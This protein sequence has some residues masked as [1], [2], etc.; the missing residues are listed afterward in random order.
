MRTPIDVSI[1]LNNLDSARKLQDS[2]DAGKTQF[3]YDNIPPEIQ[4]E[5]ERF[6]EGDIQYSELSIDTAM[7][8]SMESISEK[9][10]NPILYSSLPNLLD[11]ETW[12][13]QD[14]MLILSGVDPEAAIVDWSYQNFMGAEIRKPQIRHANW[15]TSASDLYDYPI[16]S[17][18]EYSSSELNRLIREMKREQSSSPEVEHQIAILRER[19]QNVEMWEKDETS[20]FKTTMLALRAEMVGILKTRWDSCDHDASLRRS[21]AFFVH[22]AES[23]GFAIEWASWARESG[24]I[25]TEPPA[26]SP[27][28]FDA[29]AEDYPKLLHIAV[30]AWDHARMGSQGTAKQR[31]TAFLNE[32][33]PELSASEKEAIAVI[34]NWQKAGGRPKTGG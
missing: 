33:Y 23:R 20:K 7:W 27:P 24:Y 6:I 2:Y 13:P 10:K 34:G 14:A 5:R 8:I 9:R 18:S 21:P 31:I 11:R 32:R 3:A 17:D 30:R 25:D 12:L 28:F 16:A 1:Y 19:L 22:W 26:T 4:E 15:F 29:D